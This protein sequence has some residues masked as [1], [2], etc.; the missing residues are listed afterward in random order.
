M[1]NKKNDIFGIIQLSYSK[2]L[3]DKEKFYISQILFG[4][5]L[6]TNWFVASLLQ[7]TTWQLIISFMC[8]LVT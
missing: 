6:A 1:L 8:T 3:L 4:Q 7:P 2:S 5:S